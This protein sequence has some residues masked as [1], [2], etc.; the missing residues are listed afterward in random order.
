MI[1]TSLLCNIEKY[2][3]AQSHLQ[4]HSIKEAITKLGKNYAAQGE[5]ELCMSLY[6]L[7]ILLPSLF[8]S[9]CSSHNQTV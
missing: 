1:L 2:I 8:L 4:V 5:R 3:S 7:V 9:A 6:L